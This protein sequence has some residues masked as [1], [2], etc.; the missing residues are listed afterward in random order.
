MERILRSV[1]YTLEENIEVDQNDE[2][3]LELPFLWAPFVLIGNG[4]SVVR[5]LLQEKDARLI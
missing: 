1:V 2:R 4:G 5:N 3:P